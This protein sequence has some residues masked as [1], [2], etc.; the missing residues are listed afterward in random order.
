LT[1]DEWSKKQLLLMEHG[2]NAKA[3]EYFRKNN[4]KP[5]AVRAPDYKN[6]LLQR[7]KNDLI[8]KVDAILAAEEAAISGKGVVQSPVLVTPLNNGE[9]DAPAKTVGVART[10]DT[11]SE[12]IQV[13]KINS[14]NTKLIIPDNPLTANP[15]T[16]VTVNNN[17]ANVFFTNANKG[18]ANKPKAVNAKKIADIDFDNGG[19]LGGNA[20][21]PSTS[22]SS[23][24]TRSAADSKTSASA[25]G[26]SNSSLN[27]DLQR[28]QNAKSISSKSFEPK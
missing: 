10:E 22:S 13:S 18:S 4:L 2:G 11:R 7:Y 23:S 6:T 25:S 9:A 26:N 27:N 12:D 24:Y 20:S 3:L 5:D 28:F 19:M 21:L 8:R 16:A 1:L 17:A 15:G 14:N